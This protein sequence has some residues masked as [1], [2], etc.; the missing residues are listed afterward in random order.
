MP[1]DRGARASGGMIAVEGVAVRFGGIVAVDGCSF[2]VPAGSITGLIGPN[3]AG[4]T[5]MFNVIGGALRPQAGRVLLDGADVTGLPPHRLFARGLVRTFQIPHEFARMTVLE[6]LAVVPA[7]Q[8]GERLGAA[9]LAWGRCSGST[10]WPMRPRAR[11]RAGRR[12]CSS[13][14]AP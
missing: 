3:G 1:P 11:C 13:S 4:K 2:E 10:A 5:T 9:W 6:N 12:S 14:A 7:G 8:S